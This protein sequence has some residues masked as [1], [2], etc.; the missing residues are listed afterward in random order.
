M[1]RALVHA[2][3]RRQLL[4]LLDMPRDLPLTDVF[5]SEWQAR[6]GVLPPPLAFDTATAGRLLT[7]AG[8]VDRDGDGIRER[9]GRPFR[10]AMIASAQPSTQKQAVFLQAQLARVGVA[11]EI[12]SLD[13]SL[14]GTRYRSGQWE[15][16][17]A[18]LT[19]RRGGALRGYVADFGPEGATGWGHPA[20]QAFLEGYEVPEVYSFDPLIED[21][22]YRALWP[23]LLEEAPVLL[24]HPQVTAH[25]VHRKVKGLRSPYRA[26]PVRWL[27]D[28]G[29]ENEP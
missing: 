4:A 15:A 6:R 27:E 25:V 24:L 12:Q 14:I 7:E 11:M 23:V 22:A 9:E 5:H 8:W 29:I 2:V 18:P 21:S 13:V 1:R 26:N 10:F 28:L 17:I 20:M 19:N 3:D 16:L